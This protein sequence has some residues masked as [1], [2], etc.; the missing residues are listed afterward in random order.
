MA[1]PL[2]AQ[3]SLRPY[4]W[5]LLFCILVLGLSAGRLPLA[6]IAASAAAGAMFVFPSRLRVLGVLA[7]LAIGLAVIPGLSDSLGF[8]LLLGQVGLAAV[9]P[10]RVL[11]A[12]LHLPRWTWAL[13]LAIG[14]AAMGA[15]AFGPPALFLNAAIILA[16]LCS[17]YLGAGLA[18]HLAMN[19]ARLLAWGE[20]GLVAVTRDLL[21]GRIT[22]GMLHDMAQPLNVISMANGNMGYIIDQLTIAEEERRN[23]QERVTR[24][25]AHTQNAAGIL[26]VFRWF[27]RDGSDDLRDLTVRTALERAIAATRSN[28]RH[29][30]VAVELQGNGLDYALPDRHGTLEMIAVAALLC[31]FASFISADGRKHGGK[32]LLAARLSPAHVVISV[33]CTR[34]DGTAMP[35]PKMDRATLWLVEQVAREASGDFRYLAGKQAPR[36]VMRL[37]RE[38]V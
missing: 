9:V 37:G 1:R 32:V 15:I 11:G 16:S 34:P 24:I 31:S 18:R 6:G 7:G 26:S 10:P 3:A 21:L 23:L 35:G 2:A 8:W 20:D 28:V 30:D 29:H 22:S 25:S 19:D 38:D 27:G 14:G 33:E 4:V 5:A 17:C 12:L 13:A 36:F